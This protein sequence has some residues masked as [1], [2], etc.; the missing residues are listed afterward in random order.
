MKKSSI[1]ILIVLCFVAVFIIF[2]S[3]I[4]NNGYNDGYED[5]IDINER[6]KP[7]ATWITIPDSVDSDTTVVF[8]FPFSYIKIKIVGSG[9]PAKVH[10][11]FPINDS[12]WTERIMIIN[13]KY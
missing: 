1:S 5:A 4:Y 11:C 13:P 7:K 9:G 8:D 3:V 2:Y 6:I 12:T 10:I